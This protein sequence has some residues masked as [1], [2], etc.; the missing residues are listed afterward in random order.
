MSSYNYFVTCM[1]I[2]QTLKN[3]K[4]ELLLVQV[5]LEKEFST[6][7]TN[8]ATIIILNKYRKMPLVIFPLSENIKFYIFVTQN[9]TAVKTHNYILIFTLN[10][11]LKLNSLVCNYGIKYHRAFDVH[12]S[13]E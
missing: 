10:Y 3:K 11:F 1:Q 9:N 2:F 5:F 7:I 13:R 12:S 6:N 8:F 4:L